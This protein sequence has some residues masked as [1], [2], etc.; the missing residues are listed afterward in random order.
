MSSRLRALEALV[1]DMYEESGNRLP[2]INREDVP[3]EDQH[4]FDAVISNPRTIRGLRGPAGIQL[5]S[6]RFAEV[7]QPLQEYVRSIE[8][9]DRSLTEL[10][11]LVTARELNHQ[12][13][14]TAH[15]PTALRAGLAQAT[16]DVVKRRGSVEGLNEREAAIIQLGREA[17]GIGKVET[18][19]YAR[20]YE[21]FGKEILIYLAALMGQYASLGILLR[22]FDQQL[23]PGQAPLLP[24]R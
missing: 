4:L 15:E 7:M 12:F 17:V 5:H 2:L 11:I 22:I 8:G 6:P 18:E 16:I 23:P 13:E 20:A 1:S 19:T 10:A 9:L 21:L 24:I 3:P 14:W